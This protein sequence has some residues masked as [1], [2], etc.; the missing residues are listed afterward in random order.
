MAGGAD[1]ILKK[2]GGRNGMLPA[3]GREEE[4][5]GDGIAVRQ[6]WVTAG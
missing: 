6:V 1:F 5:H 4:R 3:I 2:G